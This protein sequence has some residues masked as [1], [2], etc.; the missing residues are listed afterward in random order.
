MSH[1]SK[2][3]QTD[4]I[5]LQSH[6]V[7]LAPTGVGS[8]IQE[9]FLQPWFSA[10]PDVWDQWLGI[11]DDFR[12]SLAGLFNGDSSE[13]CP[14]PNV[15][16][17]L[18]K[19]LHGNS[20]SKKTILLAEKA[21]PSLGFVAQLATRAGYS[22]KFIGSTEDIT[23]VE[24]W[25]NHMTDDV[26]V[27]LVTHVHSN[28]NE[29]SPVGAICDLARQQDRICVV[30]ICQSAGVVPI[31]LKDWRPHFAIGSC[32]KW[33]CG[34]PGAGFLWA[35]KDS[36]R[37][38]EP[39]DV[40]WFSHEAPFEFNIHDFR[41]AKDALRFWGGTPSIAPYVV[42]RAG[43]KLIAEIGVEEIQS[44]NRS[45]AKVL[46]DALPNDAVALTCPKDQEKRGGT[47]VLDF[48]DQ[49]SEVVQRLEA[50]N[51]VF[52]ARSDGIRLSPHIYNTHEQMVHVASAFSG[53]E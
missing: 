14:Q 35:D 4:A 2:F 21:F 1:Q 33:L 6:S 41:Y 10:R 52:D 15:S 42:A 40:G 32:L 25:T 19:I 9:E 47:V 17:G 37:D 38:C 8:R 53:L 44:H 43:L 49:Q 34:G 51:V 39:L 12:Q 30:D 50:L 24:T 36:I 3:V 23:R 13:F 5:Y 46:I 45:L 18:T 31:D 28:T 16:S 7:G 26:G 22:I 27:V 29:K 11:I 48:E 20:G